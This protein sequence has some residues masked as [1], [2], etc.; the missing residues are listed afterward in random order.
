MIHRL[1][2]YPMTLQS[3]QFVDMP[4]GAQVISANIQPGQG[5]FCWAIVDTDAPI[6]SHL[7]AVLATGD[8]CGI[9]IR[10]AHFVNAIYDGPYAWH[11]FSLG[12]IGS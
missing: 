1:Y 4:R 10:T 9:E 6:V 12:D 7:F 2:K 3:D 5:M 8:K 11:V